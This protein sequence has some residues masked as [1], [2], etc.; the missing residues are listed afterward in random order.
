MNPLNGMMHQIRVLLDSGE[1]N[2][3]DLPSRGCSLS[4]LFDRLSFWK[5]GP[6]FL[7]LDQ[8]EWPQQPKPTGSGDQLTQPK[9]EWGRDGRADIS[10]TNKS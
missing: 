3:A 8:S 10:G 7:K 4:E 6:D 9:E 1:L 2:P 5:Q